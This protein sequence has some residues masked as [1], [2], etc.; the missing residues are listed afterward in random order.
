[1]KSAEHAALQKSQEYL[2][3]LAIVKPTLLIDRR[4]VEKNIERMVEKSRQNRVLLR[5]HFKTHQSAEIGAWFKDRGVQTITVSS[6][7]SAWYFAENGWT[8]ITVAFPVN[9]RQIADVNRIARNISLHLL[10]ESKE[11]VAFL[12]RELKSTARIW[13]KIDAGYH[14]T[15]IP[16]NNAKQIISVAR[17]I[18]AAEQLEF[19]GILTHAGHTYHARNV[20][21]VTSVFNETARRMTGIKRDL[22]E[23]GFEKAKISVGDTP[24]CSIVEDFTGI[25]EIRPGNFVFY[26]LMQS[27]HGI[28]GEEDI[29]VAMACPVVAKHKERNEIVIYGGAVH[30]SKEHLVD[31]SGGASYG[32]VVMMERDHWSSAV[33]SAY[34]SSVSQE[35]G[36][37]KANKDFLDYVQIGDILLILPVHACLTANL[38]KK[39]KSLDGKT[40]ARMA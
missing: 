23:E 1:M 24:G 16:W 12:N 4:K 39:Y 14:R 27:R 18:Q 9:V 34:L 25:D 26:D 6:V 40:I 30:F 19:E 22:I 32:S 33:P 17:A 37:I 28:C 13:I 2:K 10:V 3:S 21:E 15:G 20:E 31:A 29:A 38:M 35:H 5:P 8:D 11:V 36:I 7:D